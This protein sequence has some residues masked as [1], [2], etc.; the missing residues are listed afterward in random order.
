MSDAHH[1]DVDVVVA[2][3]GFAGLYAAYRLRRAGHSM[4]IF[5]AGDD[6]GGTWYWNRYPGARVDIPSVDYMYSFDPDWSRDW[7]WSEKYATQ[8]EILRYLN[9]V[10]DKHDLRRDIQFGTRV[11]HAHWDDDAGRYRVRTDRG[12]EITCRYLIMATGCLSVP[13]DLDIDGIENFTGELYFTSRWPH[14]PVDFTGKRVGVVGT[15]SSG[16]QSIPLIAAQAAQVVVFQR[17]PCFSIPAH[18]GPISPDKLAQL[19]DDDAYRRAARYS[20]G[21]VPMERSL[22]PTFSV[23]AEERRQ[24]YE[25]AW[26]LGELLEALNLYADEMINPLANSEFAEFI[27]DKIRATVHDPQTAEALCPSGYPVGS[28]RLC[29]DS[30]YYTTFNLPQVRL[31]DLRNQPLVGV[32][33]TGID[34]VGESFEFD[35]IVFATGF[36]AVTGALAAIDIVDRNGLALG[37]KWA[38]GPSTYLGLTTEGF[39]NLFLI[40]GPNSPSVLSNMA[41]SIEQHVDFV[42]DALSYLREHGFDR[43][44]PTELAEAGWMQ[45][46]DD[47]ASI[48]LF[49]QANSWYVGANIPGKPRT[50]MAYTAGVDVYRVACEEV[51]ARDYLGFR[52][53]G[54]NGSQCNDGVVR[55]LQPDIQMVLAQLEALGLPPLESLPADQAR[56][57]MNEMNLARPPGPDV[58]EIVDGTLPGAAGPLAYRLYRPA[59]PGP[60]PVVVYFHGGGWVLGDH[61][62]DDPLCRDLCVRS[63]TLIVSVDYRHAPEHRFP[64]ALDDGW[65]AVQWIAG[66]A[67]ELGGIPGQ[68]VVS[69]WSA[70]AGIAAVVCHL[71]RDAGA[72]SIVGQALLTPVTDCD[73]TRGSYL[74]NADG[75]GLTAPLMQWFFDHYADPDVRTDPR[76]APLR[77]PDLSALPP[78]IVVAAEFDPLRDEGIEYAEA[79]AAA[80]VPTELVRARGHTHLSLTM[81]D[82]VVSG[83]PIR[84]QLAGAL[85]GFFAIGAAV[86][87]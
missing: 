30:N 74:E 83:A 49:P 22:T 68:L 67:G 35:A 46:S 50:F 86:P 37:D 52:L 34:T 36:D 82:V 55:R 21:G 24:R 18:N 60:H 7:Q 53:S 15:G 63:D 10:A 64:A 65:A 42:A 33:K 45:H 28:K 40:A 9:H 59:S 81:V 75:Y 80:G 32:T 17:T 1:T 29:L 54:P 73:P 38:P 43:I 31:V 87:A 27:R 3:A 14:E 48:T 57:L 39:P 6:I 58:G 41:V 26:Q 23:S 44:E 19:A 25:R 47:A 77:A 5:E 66:H 78:A 69:G 71:A 72:P 16:I 76:I 70:G 85:R 2:G 4:R 8:P 84:A 79:L 62:S 56:A 13:K 11:T 61:T 12:D 20:F 51:V